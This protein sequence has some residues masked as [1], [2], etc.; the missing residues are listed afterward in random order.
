MSDKYFNRIEDYLAGFLTDSERAAFEVELKENEELK[1]A[2]EQQYAEW[3]SMQLLAAHRLKEKAQ[4]WLAV[5]KGEANSISSNH[6]PKLFRVRVYTYFAAASVVLLALLTGF[7][8]WADTTF[9]AVALAQKGYVGGLSG[10][11]NEK[12]APIASFIQGRAA[13]SDGKWAE[14]RQYF[15]LVQIN[16]TV[17]YF[18]ARLLAADCN[19]YLRDYGAAMAALQEVQSYSLIP[20]Q[21]YR[22]DWNILQL[23]LV[24]HNTGEEFNALLDKIIADP[25]HKYGGIS[26]RSRATILKKKMNSFWWK[27]AN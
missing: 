24:Q 25:Q 22:A 20:S 1:R 26:S 27:I 17:A 13:Y 4:S 18:D 16:D 6:I 14:A 8:W 9:D 11:K 23:Y 19:F 3:Q 12:E 2:Y 10:L 15:D 5:D 21:R 7:W